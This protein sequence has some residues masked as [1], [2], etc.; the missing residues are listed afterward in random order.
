MS[1]VEQFDLDNFLRSLTHAPGVYRMYDSEK[2]VIYV[3]KARDLKKRVSSY[4]RKTVDSAKTQALVSHIRFIDVTVTHSESE[5]LLLENI[6]IKQYKPKYNILF[7]DDKSYPYIILTDHPFPRIGSHR[8]QR[9]IKGQ[10]FGPYPNAG[11]VKDSLNLLQKLFPVRQCLD[12]EFKQR[13]RPCLQYQIKR[14]TAPC[15]HYIDETSYA[16][17]VKN[18]RDFLQGKDQT[19]LQDLIQRMQLAAE[20]QQFEQ[21]ARLRDQINVLRKLQQ[22]QIVT[23]KN[24]LG[25]IDVIVCE[26]QHNAVVVQLLFI[27]NGRILG[28]NSYYPKQSRHASTEDILHAFVEQF[29]IDQT[30][31]PSE[32]IVQHST[33]ELTETVSMLSQQAGHNIKLSSQV[34]G[35]RK[36]WLEMAITNAQTALTQHIAS[37]GKMLDRLSALQKAFQLPHLPKRMECFD[38]SHT[39]GEN[40][41]ASCVVFNENGPARQE[42]RQFNIEGIT[43]GDDYA[44]MKQALTRRYTRVKN[45]EV[46]APDIL[47]IDGGK[48]QMTQAC[49]VLTELALPDILLIGVAKGT[50]RKPGLETLIMADQSMV[51]LSP[52]SAALHL[53]QHIRDEA[54]RFAITSHRK[55]RNKQKKQ[56]ALEQIEGIGATKRRDL[57]NFFGGIQEIQNASREELAKV[58]GI[59]LEL[60]ARIYQFFH[61]D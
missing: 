27:R 9:R 56:S 42:Y 22:Q 17:D 21:A 30:D 25:C 31:L 37:H 45:G 11:S 4:F 51:T 54:H 8:G 29:Y 15:V 32:I 44:A 38:I 55:K 20:S 6:Y 47:F 52:D 16:Q 39:G 36:R 7:R 23:N 43:P 12:S 48:G 28:S 1:Q 60:A 58:S 18:V 26:T 5:A 14:C 59:S 35:D 53:I 2:T 61:K 34:R 46:K 13:T 10:Y 57:L 19:V 24:Q 50:S 33:E 3:G 49:D 40:T 41:V